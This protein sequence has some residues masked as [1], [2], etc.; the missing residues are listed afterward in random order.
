V[1]NRA[2]STARGTRAVRHAVMRDRGRLYRVLTIRVALR[3][4]WAPRPT[5]SLYMTRNTTVVA[6]LA[7]ELA[8]SNLLEASAGTDQEAAAVG[9]AL[10]PSGAAG[11][12]RA[13]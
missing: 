5:V 3:R 8:V 2:K 10:R 11:S 1:S 13:G 6:R 4:S 7:A 12:G 9:S